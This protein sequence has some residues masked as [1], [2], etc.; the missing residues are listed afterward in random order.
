MTT[1]GLRSRPFGTRIDPTRL[2]ARIAGRSGV[3]PPS[4]ALVLLLA[5]CGGDPDT[6][7]AEPIP[8]P[9]PEPIQEIGE[10]GGVPDATLQ[11]DAPDSDTASV[12]ANG[13]DED[14]DADQASPALEGFLVVN[15][16]SGGQEFGPA[17]STDV[18]ANFRRARPATQDG[19]GGTSRDPLPVVAGCEIGG[20]ERAPADAPVPDDAPLVEDPLAEDP[21]VDFEPPDALDAGESVVLTSPSGTWAT[22]PREIDDELGPAYFLDAGPDPVPAGLVLDVPGA[23]FPALSGV[24]IPDLERVRISAPRAGEAL[25]TDVRVEW[26][27]A[28]ADETY[29]LYEGFYPER[30]LLLVCEPTEPD[31]HRLPDAV[32][33]Y[34]DPLLGGA[35]FPES[36]GVLRTSNTVEDR[37]EVRMYLTRRSIEIVEG[38]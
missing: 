11:D 7:D 38:S 22:V 23:E 9:V 32:V 4:L 21:V 15:E 18:L 24:P 6:A 37:G 36:V 3:V 29:V 19:G 12:P 26:N 30:S 16:E 35:A 2:D 27:A 34:L 14:D 5:S 28:P 20:L 8:E 33:E 10:S 13:A 31:E 1:R 25:D 17:S